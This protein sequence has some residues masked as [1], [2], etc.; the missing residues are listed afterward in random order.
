MIV[1]KTPLRISFFGGGS[2]LPQ[3]YNENE[4]MVV[5]TSIDKH[6]YIA[7]NLCE[8]P[9][10]KAIYSELELVDTADKIKHDRIREALTHFGVKSN[11]ELC[12]FSDVNT[13]GTGLGSSSTFTV[14]VLHAL[15]KL[16]NVKFNKR[17]LAELACTLEIDICGEPIGKQDQYAA[18]YGGFNVIR[19]NKDGVS[20]TPVGISSHA[21][22]TL[23]SR[24]Y[25]INTNI[26]RS[27]S[28]VLATQVAGLKE[29]VNVDNTKLLVAMAEA[30]L[31]Y[32]QKNKLNDFGSLLHE[33]WT[34]KKKLSAKISN[35]NIDELYEE[36]LRNG[37]IGGKLL[38][39]GGGGYI[40][41]YVPEKI[42]PKFKYWTCKT[43]SNTKFSFTDVGT[44]V[45]HI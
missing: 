29:Q 44:I 8:A 3:F 43:N 26:S 13:K 27:A 14:G 20:V 10:V 11:I 24:L 12:S 28:D 34:V 40:L 21:T 2:D 16:R 45:E 35:S 4:G 18:T 42:T 15:F 23:Q 37:A 17:D 36:G 5:S 32:L 19:F 1:T 33:A 6:I 39:A 25:L 22:Q 41:F 9:H 7:A 38:G 31:N 30:Y